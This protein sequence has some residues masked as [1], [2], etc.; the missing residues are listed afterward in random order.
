MGSLNLYHIK[1]FHSAEYIVKLY[2]SEFPKKKFFK[3]LEIEKN[4]F[5]AVF[6][7]YF[8]QYVYTLFFVNIIL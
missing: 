2:H 3:L 1:E 7:I 8:L 6:P 5:N 4:H